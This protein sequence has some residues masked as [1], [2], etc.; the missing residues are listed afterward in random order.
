MRRLTPLLLLPTLAC[1]GSKLTKE[2]AEG[3]IAKAYPVPV[4]ALVPAQQAAQ[5]GTPDALRLQAMKDNLDPTGWFQITK[6]VNGS[7]ETYEFRATP[8]GAKAI[9]P[10]PNGFLV[11]AAQAVFVRSTGHENRGDQVQVSYEARLANPTAQ[12]PIFEALHPGAKIGEVRTRHALLQKVGGDWQLIKT[13][14]K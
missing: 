7:T 2:K 5:A 3:L 14:E 10:A 1:G 9:K 6:S 13:D 11:P 4:N 12:F 8:A